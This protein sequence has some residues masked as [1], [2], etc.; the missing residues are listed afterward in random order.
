VPPDPDTAI[1]CHYTAICRLISGTKL[2]T[3][4]HPQNLNFVPATTPKMP[5]TV[6]D[7][8]EEIEKALG[9]RKG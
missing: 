9:D 8:F 7:E 6:E 3:T 1:L 2:S 5:F 4:F